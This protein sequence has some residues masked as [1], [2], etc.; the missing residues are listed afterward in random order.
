MRRGTIVWLNLEDTFPPEFG[1]TRP[2]IVISNS[3]QN[4]VLE[5]LVAVPLSTQPPHNWPLRIK[6]G[7][8]VTKVSFAVVPGIRQ[9]KKSRVLEPIEMASDDFLRLLDTALLAY[10][11]D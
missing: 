9:V 8:L 4:A 1:K 3:E 10:L 6:Y 2:A 5:T 7:K 11:G